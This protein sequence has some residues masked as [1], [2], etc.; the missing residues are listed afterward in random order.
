MRARSE[1]AT[2]DVIS[3]LGCRMAVGRWH[4]VVASRGRARLH[5]PLA[6]ALKTTTPSAEKK[7]L[8]QAQVPEGKVCVSRP[9]N[10]NRKT[11]VAWRSRAVLLLA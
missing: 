1:R 8:Y 6:A 9:R 5:K 7:R 4:C 3:G 2:R 10:D 11:P